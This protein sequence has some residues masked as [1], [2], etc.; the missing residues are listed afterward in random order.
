M[1]D[2]HPP[3]FFLSQEYI[4][5]PFQQEFLCHLEVLLYHI[6]RSQST[7]GIGIIHKCLRLGCE[8]CHVYVPGGAQPYTALAFTFP[9]CLGFCGK[10][11]DDVVF[12][13][14]PWPFLSDK[15]SG[16]DNIKI[17]LKDH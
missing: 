2:T 9:L 14:L 15:H 7:E 6:R 5:R 8:D 1:F 10:E 11:E 3:S 17:E 13:P 4:I 12:D 16:G